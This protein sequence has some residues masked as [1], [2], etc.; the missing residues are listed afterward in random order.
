MIVEYHND[1]RT[2]SRVSLTCFYVVKG[3]FFTTLAAFSGP[4]VLLILLSS[5]MHSFFFGMSQ[6]VD[7]ATSKVLAITWIEDRLDYFGFSFFCDF[8]FL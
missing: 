7:M 1:M 8:I 5:P 4:P 6:I 3:F 2:F